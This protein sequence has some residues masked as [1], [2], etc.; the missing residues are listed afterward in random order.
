MLQIETNGPQAEQ[1]QKTGGGAPC[2]VP[3]PA[4][5]WGQVMWAGN[6]VSR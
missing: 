3:L 6:P 4:E 2:D 1:K 5:K